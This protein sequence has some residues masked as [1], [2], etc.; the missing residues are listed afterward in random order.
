[1]YTH[2][3]R[4]TYSEISSGG[5]ADIAQIADYFQD[6]SA[7]QS[8]TLGVGMD[9]LAQEHL[10]WL[11]TSWQIVVEQY[12]EYG[13]QI[14]VS[15]WPYSFDPI[16]GYRNFSLQ[17]GQGHRLAV[18]NSQWILVNT[19][20]GHPTRITDDI[21]CHY[22]MD[23]KADMMYAPR[24]IAFKEVQEARDSFVVPRAFIDTNQHVNNAQYIRMALEYIPVD[25]RIHQV[26]VEYRKAAVMGDRIYPYVFEDGQMVKVMLGDGQKKPYAVVEFQGR[27]NGEKND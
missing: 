9:Y 17:D 8:D 2:D 21:T 13:D 7:F 20:N 22:S 5:Y 10:A 26:R 14:A 23:E 16:F 24:K 6:C 3:R 4:V 25:F 18:A 12:P 1:M 19:E 27:N 11:L 15:T